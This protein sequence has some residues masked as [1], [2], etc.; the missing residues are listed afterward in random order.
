MPLLS[1]AINRHRPGIL[2]TQ[3]LYEWDHH[4]DDIEPVQAI[5]SVKEVFILALPSIKTL[6]P[7]NG[8]QLKEDNTYVNVADS[9]EALYNAL[10]V[11][12][13]AGIQL[14]G[15]MIDLRGLAANKPAA[16]AVAIGA[17]YWSVDT[18]PHG[19][20]IEVSDGTNWAVI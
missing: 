12:K 2:A 6:D 3:S 4:N 17:T 13:D 19:T 1:C 9:I 18:D 14:T 16:N 10:V 5:G 7:I 15:S 8:R 11:N 20:A